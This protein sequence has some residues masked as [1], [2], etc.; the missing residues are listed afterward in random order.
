MKTRYRFIGR[1]G[2]QY[3]WQSTRRLPNDSRVEE[4]R[5]GVDWFWNQSSVGRPGRALV[6][7]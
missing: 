4:I 3:V 2:Q 6:V 7:N 5:C 1:D